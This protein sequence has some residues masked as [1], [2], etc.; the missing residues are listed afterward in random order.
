M[1]YPWL[2]PQWQHLM[3]GKESGRLPHA[4]LLTGPEGLGKHHLAR[5]LAHALLCRT[6]GPQGEACGSCQQCRLLAASS[7][8]DFIALSPEEGSSVIKI[9]QI[10]A[11]TE[12]FSYRSQMGG[13]KVA[14]IEP[15]EQ[16]N[17]AA[18]N[19]LLKTLEEPGEATLLILV[20]STQGRLPA[21]IRSRCQKLGFS[22][23]ERALAL[24]W[25]RQQ[26]QQHPEV[27]LDL[28]LGAPLKALTYTD[29]ARLERRQKLF[30]G[31][32]Q[33]FQG[34]QDPVVL[35]GN[36]HSEGLQESLTWMTGWVMDMIRLKSIPPGS[37]SGG[38][39]LN[40]PDLLGALQPMAER[41]DFL[42]LFAH[43]DRLKKAGRLA[44]TQVNSQLLLEDLFIPWA[45]AQ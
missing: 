19:A 42:Q 6:P 13:Y 43:L 22:P 31:L 10:R 7:H 15:A 21:T 27:A 14:L 35:A 36:W 41:L 38:A 25:L 45:K 39:L 26:G 20:S 18:A 40:N 8:P 33:L 4:L 12:S 2:Q 30:T 1:I 9:D 23:P 3:R 44:E 28:A 34:Q 37:A 16:L 17:P 11:L 24:D 32:Q 5:Q 29:E